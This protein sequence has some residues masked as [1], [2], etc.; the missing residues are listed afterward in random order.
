MDSQTIR[1]ALGRLQSEPDSDDAWAALSDSVRDAGGD[2][3]LD[4]LL[5]LFERARQRHAARGEWDAVARLLEVAVRV[6]E[7]QPGETELLREHA[8]VL[9]NELFDD[10][11]AL[12]PGLRLLELDQGDVEAS[13]AI[14]E[15]ESKRGR[16]AELAQ[17]YVDEAQGA[18]DDTYK[19]SMLMHAAEMDVRFGGDGVDLAK[20]IERLEQAVR[21]DP[22]NAK[23]GRLLELVHRRAGHWAEVARVLERLAD[24]AD[25]VAD[26]VAAGT[27]LARVQAQHLGDDERAARAYEGVMREAPGHPEAMEFLIG[28]YSGKER[29]SDL[30]GL[31]ERELAAKKA[32]EAELI[33]DM[34]QIAM[35]Y[36]KKLEHA[37]AAEP[38]FSRIAKI[39]P[40]NEALLS[41]Y[42]EYCESLGDDGRLMEVLQTAQRSLKDGA[43]E[44]AAIAVELARLA[45]GQE[46]AQKAI[47]QYK[48]VLRSDPD[49]VEARDKLKG[50]YKQTQSHNALVELLRQQLERLPQEA[51]EERLAVLREVA[52]IY[53][54][55]IRSDTALLSVLNQIVQLDEK[56]DEHDV[57]EMR[58]IVQLYDK[59]GRARDMITYQLK[60]AEITPDL[61]EKKRLYRAAGRRWLEQFSNAQNA[62]DAFASLLKLEPSDREAR[63]R[64]D[65]LYRKRRA[66]PQLF[67]LFE[68]ELADTVGPARGALMLEMAGL[69]SERLN[70]GDVAVKLY[71]DVLDGDPS[72]LDVLDALERHAERA[73]DWASLADALERRTG[74]LKDDAQRLVVLQKLGTVYA[75]HLNDPQAATRAWR[76]VLEL[77]PG[78]QRALRVLRDASL[79]AGDYDGLAELYA[80]QNDWE[81][82]AEVLSNA[83][84]RA[85][86]PALRVDLSYRAAAVL[87]DKLGHRERAFRSYER[88]LT[89]DPSDTRAARALIPLYEKDEKWVRLPALYE[90]LLEHADGI[91]DKLGYLGRL[92]EIAGKHLSDRR[93]AAAYARRA[94]ELAPDSP[95][96]LDILED[97]SRAAGSWDSFVEAVEGRLR[98]LSSDASPTAAAAE[99]A[100]AGKKKKK[101]RGGEEGTAEPRPAL[102]GDLRRLL[103]L[104]LAR[105]LADELARHDDAIA[106]YRG[107]LERDPRD[108]EASGALDRLF[109]LL[110]RRDDLRTLFDLRV[111]TVEG[112]A[113]RLAILGEWATLEEEVFEDPERAAV[114]Y[115]RMLEIDPGDEVA[116]TTL[117]RLLLSLDDAAGAAAVMEQRRDR[118]SD[119][120]RAES[121]VA[122]AE[123]YIGRLGRPIDALAS[124]EE[125]LATPETAPTA[126]HLLERLLETP[127]AR[128]RAAEVLA[129]RYAE[130]GDAR[131]EAQVLGILLE[132]TTDVPARLVL[133]QRLATVYEEKL[134]SFS[135]ALDVM[136]RAVRQS[137]D[138]LEL[139]ERAELLATEAG[140]PTDLGDAFREVLRSKLEPDLEVELCERASRLHEDRLGDP[141]GATPYLER[142]L[143]LRPGTESA[144]RRLKDILTAAER[145]GE[146]EALYERAVGAS[147]D[148]VRKVEMLAEVALVC[149]EI[150]EDT[151]KAMRHYERILAIDPY[152]ETAVRALD[153]LYTRGG[154]ERELAALLDRRLETAVGDDSLDLK[155]RLAR[156]QLALHEPEKAMGHVEDVLSERVNDAD[157]RQLAERLLEIG[158]LKVRAA[159]VLEA[160]Y[161]SRDEVRDLA[162][163]LA[164]RLDADT[165]AT[166]DETRELLRRIAVLRNDR[167]RDDEGAFEAFARLCPLDPSDTDSRDQLIAIGERQGSYERVARVLLDTAEKSTSA[168]LRGEILTRVALL[169]EDRLGQPEQAETVYRRVLELDPNDPRGALPAARSLERLY[170][171]Q[172]ASE[173]LAEMLRVQIRLEE[174]VAVRR[175]LLGRLGEISETVLGDRQGA[176]AAW[177]S[178]LEDGGDDEQALSALDRLYESTERYRDLVNVLRRRRD[179]T[180]DP[181]R[182]RGLLSRSAE[183]LWRKLDAGL[184]AIDEYRT[185]IDEFGPST[186][187]LEA[188]EALFEA[189]E[190][191]DD[192]ADTYQRH[193]DIA[194]SDA[195]RLSLLGKLGDLERLRRGDVPAALE[196][197]RRALAVDPRHAESRAALQSLLEA[198]DSGVRRDAAQMLRPLYE[199]DGDHE[200]LVNV[201][202]IEVS[203]TDD[204]VEKLAGL[205]SAIEVAAGPLGDSNRAF[206]YAERAVRHAVGHAEVEEWFERLE[207]LAQATGRHADHVTLLCNVVSNL[208]DGDVQLGVTLKIADLARRELKDKRLAREYYTKALELRADHPHALA[209]LETLYEEDGDAQRLLDVLE[210]RAEVA[211][212]DDERK[213]LLYRRATLLAGELGDKARAIEVYESILD[214]S[215]EEEALT[216]LEGLYAAVER[217]RDLVT[218][219]ERQIDAGRGNASDL[220]VK[221]AGV[222]ARRQRDTGRAFEELEQ[223]LGKDRHHEG[224]IAELERLLGEATDPEH[225]GRAAELLEP[226]YLVRADWKRVRAALEARLDVA[227]DPDDR[228]ELLTRLAHLFE[229]QEEDY[230]AALETTAK[231]LHEDLADEKTLA[232]LERLARVAGAGQRLAELFAAELAQVTGD[233]PASARLARRTGEL[234]DQLGQADQALSFYRRALAFHGDDKSLFSAI[235]GILVRERRHEERVALHRDA[236]EQRFDPAERLALLHTVGG[237]LEKELARP[238]EAIDTYRSALEVDERD[239]RSL[240]AL[241]ALYRARSRWDD[242]AELYLTR[243]EQAESTAR[244]VEFRLA[245]SRLHLEQGQT[246]RAVD[247]L[248]EVVRAD[249]RNAEAIAELDKLREDEQQK[250]RV[251][252]I[253]RPLYEAAD[254]WRR[255]VQLNEDRFALAVDDE[256]VMVLRETAELWETRG[257]DNKRAR[258]AYGA[259]LRLEPEDG[260]VRG[261][262]E[263][264]AADTKAWDE[265]AQTYEEILAEHADLASVREYLAVLARVHDQERDDPRR[266]LAA[267]DR[268]YT[269][270]ESDPVPL[271]AMERLAILL[272]DWPTLVNVLTAKTEIVLDDEER[273]SLFRRIGEAKRDLLED[274]PGAIEAYTRASE[275]DPTSAF[276]V[277][278]LIELYEAADNAERL[279]EL[280]ERRVELVGSDDP[281]LSYELLILAAKCHEQRLSDPGRAIDCLV[282]ALGSKPGDAG[283]LAALDRLYRAEEKWPDL[284]DNLRVQVNIA[285]GPAERAS[286][287][288]AIG[289]V[290][291]EKLSSYEDSLEAFRQALLQAPDDREAVLRVQKLAE[292]HESLRRA[293][294]EILVP[295]LKST[296]KWEELVALY[297]LRLSVE[298][299]A[300]ER[301]HTL[302][303]IAEV[304]ESKL[305]R[306]ADAL[307]ALLRALGERPE[308]EDLHAEI[309]RLAALSSGWDRYAS[310]LAERASSTFEAELARDL[311]VRLGKVAEVELGD[312]KRAVESFERAVEQVG[313]TADLLVALDRLYSGLGDLDKVA[314]ILERRAVLEFDPVTQAEIHH[315]LATIQAT[316]FRDPARALGSLRSALERV[317]GHPAAVE[318]LEKLADH[319]DLFDEAADVLEGVYRAAGNTAS[320]ARLYE[321]H[322]E[323]ADSVEARADMRRR[324]ADVLEHEGKDPAGGLKVLEEGIVEAPA[325]SALLEE[326]ERLARVTGGWAGAAAAL[327]EAIDRHKDGILPDLACMLSLRR[328]GWL[329]DHAGDSAGAEAALLRGL[330]FDPVN[331]ELLQALEDL[332]RASGRSRELAETL[333]RRAKLQSDELSRAEL[334]QQAKTL[335]DELGDAELAESL[336]RELISQDDTNRWALAELA[337]LRERAGDFA[338][339][340]ELIVRRSEVE[341]DGVTV[342]ELRQRAAELA[343]DQLGD[344]TRAIELYEE[345]FEDDPTNI[346][347]AAALRALFS[348]AGLYR[349]LGR[350]LERLVDVAESPGRR[351]ELRLELA[352]LNAERFSAQDAAIDLCRAVLDE[353]PARAEA[354]VLLS[355][356]YEQTQRDEELAELLSSQIDA[357][358]ARGDANA[359]LSFQVRLGEVYESR[360]GDRARAIETYQSVLAR[361]PGHRGALECVARLAKSEGRLDEAADALDRLLSASTGEQ[362][363]RLALSLAD[364][365]EELGDTE[366]AAAALERGLAA[367]ER[368]PGL[369]ERLRKLY[370][371]RGA[372]DRLAAMLSRDAELEEAVNAKVKLLR[373]AARIHAEHRSDH[374]AAA[375]LLDRAAQIKPD[376]REILLELCDEYNASGRGKAAAQVLERIVQSF[377]NKRTKELGEI[378]R[379]LASAYLS[380]GDG[381]RAL[382][383]LDRAFRIEPGNI[384]VLAA[385]GNVAIQVGDFKKAQQMYRALLL[386]KLDE[387]GPIKKALVFVRLGD[388]HD[389]LGERPKAIQMYERALQTDAALDEAKTKL[390]ALKG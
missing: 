355:Q 284:L 19:S 213:R 374:P 168:E 117:S 315:R 86:E 100:P 186:A 22:S 286:L 68:V 58:E 385:L 337:T 26:R 101:R 102:S 118:L 293:A 38:W 251:V 205:R 390:A 76:R 336:L 212:S 358:R 155:L 215:L 7:N 93:A 181:D 177:R 210:R 345:L 120:A 144:F 15:L 178:R 331:D 51:Y 323:F 221:I 78:H 202:D 129:E 357:A 281:E 328:A 262:Y 128:P 62:A 150:I 132:S 344:T 42:R 149:E 291:A 207:R 79:Q 240:D 343:R 44:K 171:A 152:H 375:E 364:V 255:L 243:A 332:Q 209:A 37:R 126:V 6:A 305:G 55:Y 241:T 158:S 356:L 16:S 379:R 130:S 306:V 354:V 245:L 270:D 316:H 106:V 292:E 134:G 60:L 199:A 156:L 353:E 49:N 47:E 288:K 263:R 115:R 214:M 260:G 48:A 109:R 257:N 271:D 142:M 269:T 234:F 73:K 77:S 360:L 268:L 290:L 238:D 52:S 105:V 242:L 283:A 39:Q 275:L 84:D 372:W 151:A 164:A 161:D 295:V 371:S 223:A 10:E 352:R 61:D 326:I 317:P 65:E 308:A 80:S 165:D 160:V 265:L 32:G 369:R 347:A 12:V 239:E 322:V 250:E 96:A 125:A 217:W 227:T 1:T 71:R 196:V 143:T 24:R 192:L 70:R 318:A 172:G 13:Q 321:K 224:A 141:I 211:D 366:A 384:A 361:E 320:L 108:A 28:F 195:V 244:G 363:V 21:L 277:D 313:D 299:E 348:K 95:V 225:R 139:W 194:E 116:L 266:A 201:L 256:K 294:S 338:Q 311:Y 35:L 14:E 365:R 324:L 267:Y 350:L 258:K 248:E 340:F 107:L 69:A 75:E 92:V 113:E 278:C 31:Y 208:F 327:S 222:A 166:P 97:S 197:Y 261:H 370:E 362:A 91:E 342:R 301:T 233:D 53:R 17:R 45:E 27:R 104:K 46:N 236:L 206:G 114:L 388:I 230:R 325:D 11:G 145:W 111:G 289:Q 3:S 351:S 259:A 274:R 247:Q 148:P 157:A 103:E 154:K 296:E 176:I 121:Q 187:S 237:L 300:A 140:R 310:A 285:P 2:L 386:Q 5:R 389:K 74:A 359:E 303:A 124:A 63:E 33:G 229:E 198:P 190:R 219:Y 90:L 122:L 64:L 170:A 339:A 309:A 333:R 228:R 138:R 273:A 82:L 25:E 189:A 302:W 279:V 57:E 40:A 200:R 59:L 377:G 249:G 9:K 314:D 112:D 280:Y 232:E 381:P 319:R 334:Y 297:E 180:S 169:Y 137:P 163:V 367:D 304:L 174:S 246:E 254:D 387:S 98:T 147:E 287:Y 307:S 54:E 376:D 264:L 231:L 67:E 282:R 341:S 185:L 383:E 94:Y 182:R 123:L 346:D 220:R 373:Q 272:S 235:D 153:R 18:T 162:R 131:R 146:L 56:L 276:T 204:P 159:R 89:A 368:N 29:W 298:T 378:H 23:A 253:L 184:E 382:E 330:E 85:K 183:I 34:L 175:D 380:D 173:K 110:D 252:E 203:A 43:K 41:F 329:K 127:S 36:W 135:D 193:L 66:W 30:V 312:P 119:A 20:A 8:R 218:L 188:L 136:L 72:R 191:W 133:E 99:A 349:E 83:A 4:E 335:A 88:V 179:L 50:F 226:V 87:E 167:L 216:A 81:G